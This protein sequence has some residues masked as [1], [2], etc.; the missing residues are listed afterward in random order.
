MTENF[1]DYVPVG[2]IHTA[3]NESQK[4]CHTALD[5]Q[6]C[7]PQ[8]NNGMYVVSHPLNRA[9]WGW[10]TKRW[11]PSLVKWLVSFPDMSISM[12]VVLVL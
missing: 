2:P 12:D 4:I 7:P 1:L 5:S 8:G 9:I 11:S 6:R 3:S 10:N